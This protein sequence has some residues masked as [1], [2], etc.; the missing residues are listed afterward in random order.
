[1]REIH[2]ILLLCF[3]VAAVLSDLRTGRIPN[4]VV[5]AGL[6]CAAAYRLFAEGAAGLLLWLGGA[7][8]PVLVFALLFYFR[9]IGAGDVKLLCMAGGFLGPSGCFG[10]IVSALIWGGL[11]SAAILLRRRN[12]SERAACLAGYAGRRLGGGRWEPYLE[13]TGEDARFC[14]SVPVLLGILCH[15]VTGG[16]I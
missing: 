11:I 7:A 14:F 3:A 16:S 4:G 12:F 1:M 10:C 13:K 9:M 5:T 8:L 6:A 15:I 2:M